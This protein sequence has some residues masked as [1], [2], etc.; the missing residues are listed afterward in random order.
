MR[1]RFGWGLFISHPKKAVGAVEFD[2]CHKRKAIRIRCTA[3]LAE[4]FTA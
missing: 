2:E 1:S 4:G 3:M